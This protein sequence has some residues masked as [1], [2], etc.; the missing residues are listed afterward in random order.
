[1]LSS[2]EMTKGTD[3]GFEVWESHGPFD[4]QKIPEQIICSRKKKKVSLTGK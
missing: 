2:R 4:S 1:M 3:K